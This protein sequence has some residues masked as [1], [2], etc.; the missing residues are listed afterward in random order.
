LRQS[1]NIGRRLAH[2]FG[3]MRHL[4]AGIT[5]VAAIQAG[6]PADNADF[7]DLNLIPSL[8]A[9]DLFADISAAAIEPSGGITRVGEAVSQLDQTTRQNAALVEENAAAAESQK[10]PAGNP[11]EAVSVFKLAA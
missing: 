6:K 11:A 7:Y 2:A 3:V 8:R 9:I 4:L 1:L 5:V 10:L